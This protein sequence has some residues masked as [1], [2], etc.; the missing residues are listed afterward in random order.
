MKYDITALGEIL[1]DFAPMGNDN[2]GDLIFARKAGGAPLNLLAA[3]AKFGGKAAFIGK[4]GNDM[5]GSF[6]RSTVKR[7]GISDEALVTDH[8]H[9]TTLAFVEL[10]DD[11]DRDF[12]FF[13]NHGADI[14]LTEDDIDEEIIK[15]SK[16][17]H[18]GSLSLTDEPSRSAAEY[19]LAVAKKA[20]CTVSYDPNYRAPLWKDRSSAIEMMK[21]HID[22]T[23][24]LKISSE[25]LT[26]LFGDDRSRAVKSVL[27]L[28]VSVLLVT[29]GGN[30]AALYMG[31]N[32]ISLPA[33]DVVPIDTTGAGDIFF[34]T[35]LSEWI[36]N[37]SDLSNIT[38]EKACEY[39][40]TAIKVAG[41]STE[42]H[43]GVASIPESKRI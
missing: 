35:F 21:K 7:Y 2:D 1:I 34:G 9:N 16:I 13:R 6:L 26:M 17:F 8:S 37:G 18:F 15:N 42:R 38:F 32:G 14:Y 4:V 31:E 20:G 19:A 10:G 11:G 33:A 12:S 41:K 3:I 36:E 40:K 25:E 5:L 30:G 22:K 24:I 29:D 28:G 43:G 39:L 23:D 27:E